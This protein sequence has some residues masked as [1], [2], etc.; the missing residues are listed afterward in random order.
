MEKSTWKN[1][2][3]IL[4]IHGQIIKPGQQFEAYADEI[5]KP[6]RD[7]VCLIL[8][9]NKNGDTKQLQEFPFEQPKRSNVRVLAIA[10]VYNEIKYLPLM[11]RFWQSQGI[12]V[13]YIDNYSTDGTWEWLQQHEI[14]SHQVDTQG[15]FDLDILQREIEKTLHIV[16][17]DWFIYSSADLFFAFDGD[18][19]QTLQDLQDKGINQVQ[20]PCLT[21]HNTGEK[22]KSQFFGTYFYHKNRNKPLTMISRYH[23]TISLRGD[24]IN[25]AG[26]HPVELNGCMINFGQTKTKAEREETYKRRELAWKGGLNTR[27]GIHY[28]EGAKRN[29]KWKPSELIDIRYCLE[30]KY[31]QKIQYSLNS[32]MDT[33]VKVTFLSKKDYAGSGWRIVHALRLHYGHTYNV[34]AIVKESDVF[35]SIRCG[36]PIEKMEPAEVQKRINASDIIHFKGDWPVRDTWE[37]FHIP[38]HVKRVHLVS[39]SFFRKK[40][41]HLTKHVALQKYD[42]SE[43]QADF[44]AATTPDL[45]YNNNWH[46]T[47]FSYNEFEYK[48]SPD[49]VF[50]VCHIPSSPHKKGTAII[51]EAMRLVCKARGDVQYLEL[52][53]IPFDEVIRN[54]SESHLYIDQLIIDAYSNATVVAM[55]MGIPVCSKIDPTLY[56]TDCPVIPISS[57]PELIAEEIQGLLKWGALKKL[58]KRSYLFAKR[59]HGQIVDKWHTVYQKLYEPVKVGVLICT[60]DPARKPFFDFLLKRLKKQALQPDKVLIIDYPNTTGVSDLAKRYKTGSTQLF[61]QG[62]DIVVYMEDDDYYPLTYLEEMVQ[63]WKDN[64]RPHLIGHSPTRYYHIGVSGYKNWGFQPH[65][66]AHATAVSKGVQ[67]D[68]CKD[69]DISFD[70]ALWK[71]NSF[72]VQTTLKTPPISIKH[73]VGLTVPRKWHSLTGKVYPIQDQDNIILKKYVDRESCRFYINLVN[74]EVTNV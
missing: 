21:F 20:L 34:E 2:G 57:Q 25:I 7:A 61:E 24:K 59:E 10:T 29:W 63:A 69:T 19:R 6:F 16:K 47:P 26:S 8:H 55:S 12:E 31:Y 38:E 1:K 70:I 18:I 9:D 43:Y 65:C 71:Y 44:K 67:L 49:K 15:A 28:I 14:P 3:G 51:K 58:S 4:R 5:P 73:N 52:T 41:D 62:M 68:V 39:G 17:P 54:V 35:G 50:K 30:Y 36:W 64:G 32:K 42:E 11:V 60:C 56:D 48:W 53:D 37:G 33:R 46:Y 22:Q 40:Q 66:S 74:K 23:P 72:K 13:Y 45:V 27:Y